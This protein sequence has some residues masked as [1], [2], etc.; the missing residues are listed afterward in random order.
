MIDYTDSVDGVP[1][2]RHTVIDLDG[3]KFKIARAGF[4][5]RGQALDDLVSDFSD[6]NYVERFPKIVRL[7][8]GPFY[9]D[10]DIQGFID[11]DLVLGSDLKA[12]VEAMRGT[13][14]SGFKKKVPESDSD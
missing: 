11:K 2:V 6:E 7:A 4:G 1:T 13:D 3:C 5:A 12:I 8:M 10:E 14:L 9:S